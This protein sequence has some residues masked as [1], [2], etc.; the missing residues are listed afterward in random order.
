LSFGIMAALHK[1]P[2][3]LAALCAGEDDIQPDYPGKRILE[4]MANGRSREERLPSYVAVEIC[5]LTRQGVLTPDELFVA[6]VRL[7]TTK[8]NLKRVLTP[9]LEA[10]TRAAW[11]QAIAEQQFN[12]RN[13]ASSFL[14]F[15]KSCPL[16]KSG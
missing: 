1:R 2:D 9:A 12:L 6:S 8:S 4:V 7:W 5:R 10:W 3:A 11:T 13:P 16:V 15:W 14:R